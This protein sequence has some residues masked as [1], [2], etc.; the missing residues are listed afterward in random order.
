MA[1][2]VRR[3]R[4]GAALVAAALLAGSGAGVARAD[5]PVPRPDRPDAVAAEASDPTLQP[6]PAPTTAE[7]GPVTGL[8]MP[9][10]VSLKA[11]EGFM[12]RGPSSTHRIDWV[13][14]RRH[15]PL[16]VTGEYGHWRRVE[17]R[18]G[19][20]GWMH[21]ALLSGRRTAI[22]EADL[23]P[24]R[25]RPS[26]EA[27]LR[28]RLERGVIVHVRD[29]DGTWCRIEAGGKRGWSTQIALWGLRPGEVRED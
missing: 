16:R 5:A 2:F 22:V 23:L 13:L 28:A 8:P 7:R 3:P 4:L 1:E 10:F 29:C 19:A 26:E 6:E 21:H 17:D 18:E 12:R 24:L 9:R 20:V 14:Q 25:R 11:A 27:P 15:M